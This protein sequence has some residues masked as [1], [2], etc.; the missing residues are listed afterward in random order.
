MIYG[1]NFNGTQIPDA[2][3]RKFVKQLKLPEMPRGYRA[4]LVGVGQSEKERDDML[5][6]ATNGHRKLHVV[7]KQTAAGIWYGIY[8]W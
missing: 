3:R 7:E 8:A 5:I 1:I 2:I 4:S 6:Q